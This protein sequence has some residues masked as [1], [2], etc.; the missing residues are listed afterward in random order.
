M[1]IDNWHECG[2]AKTNGDPKFWRT[3]TRDRVVGNCP[4]DKPL[5]FECGDSNGPKYTSK[6][7][8]AMD[9]MSNERINFESGSLWQDSIYK[10]SIIHTIS[11]DPSC[12]SKCD[13]DFWLHFT[14]Q[15]FCAG[16]LD[17]QG[18]PGWWFSV[19]YFG[20]KYADMFCYFYT[21]TTLNYKVFYQ[22][23]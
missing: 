12:G 13:Y 2:R 5:R 10:K 23:N 9:L 4:T 22:K 21:I 1:L 17:L 20:G 11:T 6:I 3:F 18:K 19:S 8:P 14:I 7:I 15:G 16:L